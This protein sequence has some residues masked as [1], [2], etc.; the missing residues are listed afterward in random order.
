MVSDGEWTLY[1]P[2]CTNT[3][4]AKVSQSSTLTVTPDTPSSARRHSPL[5]S[6]SC[7]GKRMKCEAAVDLWSARARQTA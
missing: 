2:A 5:E 3:G 1:I 6:P 7:V 4:E